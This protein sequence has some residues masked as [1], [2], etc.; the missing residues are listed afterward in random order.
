M[1]PDPVGTRVTGIM[2]KGRTNSEM[3]WIQESGQDVR[4]Q[5]MPASPVIP[6]ISPTDLAF[7]PGVRTTAAPLVPTADAFRALYHHDSGPN[8]PLT[9]FSSASSLEASDTSASVPHT[10]FSSVDSIYYLASPRDQPTSYPTSTQSSQLWSETGAASRSRFRHPSYQNQPSDIASRSAPNLNA[11]L[12]FGP[13]NLAFNSRA[14]FLSPETPIYPL[15]QPAHSS[16]S[17]L[18]QPF[19]RVHSP[20]PSHPAQWGSA[21]GQP[22]RHVNMTNRSEPLEDVWIRQGQNHPV[23]VPGSTTSSQGT[24]PG[25]PLGAHQPTPFPSSPFRPP[26]SIPFWAPRTFLGTSIARDA[27]LAYAHQLYNASTDSGGLTSIPLPSE[28]TNNPPTDAQHRQLF[29][30][31]NA[32][33]SQ[34]PNHLPTLLLLSCAQ[35]SAKE[36]DQSQETCNTILSM[37]PN[38]VE[39]M[40]NMGMVMKAKGAYKEAEA[41]WIK[42]IHLRPTYWDAIDNLV[43]VLCEPQPSLDG[44]MLV[45]RYDKALEI[46]TYVLNILIRPDGLILVLIPQAHIHRLQNLLFTRGNLRGIT[47]SIGAGIDD[48]T[49]A[50][51]LVFRAPG[52]V[53]SGMPLHLGDVVMAVTVIGLLASHDP[54]SPA[55]R[56]ISHALSIDYSRFTMHMLERSVDWLI[57]VQRARSQLLA[58]LLEIGDGALPIVL[59]T[60]EMV[61]R[62]PSALFSA[63]AHKLPGLCTRQSYEDLWRASPGINEEATNKLTSSILLTLAKLFQTMDQGQKGDIVVNNAHIP[64]S[65]SLVIIL[66][67]MALALHPTASTYNNLGIIFYT[68]QDVATTINAHGQRELITGSLLALQYYKKGLTLDPNHPHILTNYGSLLKDQGRSLDAISM[69]KRALQIKPDFEIALANIANVIKDTGKI[70]EAIEY[71]QRA[72]LLSSLLPDVVCGYVNAMAS[73]CDWRGG[74]GA[75]GNEPIVD[76]H[77]HLIQRSSRDDRTPSGWMGRLEETARKQLNE[78]YAVNSGLLRRFGSP[79]Y[80]FSLVETAYGD[81]ITAGERQKWKFL[82]GYYYTEFSR[83][84]KAVNELAVIICLMEALNRVLQRRCYGETLD[85]RASNVGENTNLSSG[86]YLRLRLPRALGS[87]A[88]PALLPF[89]CFPHALDV[90]VTRLVAHRNAL[91]ISY[92]ALTSSWSPKAVHTPPPP[93]AGRLNIGYVSSDFNNHPLAHLMLSVFKLHDRQRFRVFVYATSVSDNSYYRQRIEQDAQIFRD[94]SKQSTEFIVNQ[95]INDQIHILIN[96][97]GYTRAARNDIFAARPSSLQVSLMGYAGTSG[98]SWCDYLV[99]DKQAC[100]KEAFGSYRAA[101]RR[102]RREYE[103]VIHQDGSLREVLE[104]YVDPESLDMS[105]ALTEKYIHLPHS[106]FVTDHRQAFR[107]EHLEPHLDPNQRWLT[108]EK[109]RAKLRQEIFPDLNEST[110]IFA[111][112]SQIYKIC[113]AAFIIWIRLLQRVPNSI[114]WLLRFPAAGEEHLMRTA[115]LWGG[116]EIASRVRFTNIAPKEAHI[117]RCR[118]A[119]L[120]LDTFQCNAHTVATDVLWSGTPLLTLPKEPYKMCSRVA[121]SIALATGFGESM[122]VANEREYEERAVSLACSI[123]YRDEVNSDGTTD[124]RGVGELMELRK[125]LILNRDRM[126]L[127]DTARWTRNLEKGFEEIWRRWEDSCKPP[128]TAKDEDGGVTVSDSQPFFSG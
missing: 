49:T 115:L 19:A 23:Q 75:I 4:I 128:W 104:E 89:H 108:E 14:S 8:T 86:H 85:G 91:K 5:E 90:R 22:G 77:F 29:N 99:C 71:Y 62:I 118:V 36:Y 18:E 100:P 33:R 42:A 112:F 94:V 80:W 48:Y 60:P 20:Y 70:K 17:L 56:E 93:P 116:H 51:E 46:L 1:P 66:Y 88:V 27:M 69:Y 32:I 83:T 53:E 50:L 65:T 120:V 2:Q 126:P 98:A 81:G 57:L 28:S 121:S 82:I 59:L 13:E 35:F 38:Y 9:S 117:R 21:F 76:D 31:L 58:A 113:P 47:G 52:S 3:Q 125:N 39:A 110:V 78:V 24:L 63:F 103:P 122:I 40:S 11:P 26:I 109:L 45:P 127:F 106:Y 6:A 84:E 74:R 43:H 15:H 95:I 124:R 72:L 12:L 68:T 114:L 123:S 7:D 92:S 67:Y 119:D 44:S 54:E 37:D 107:E 10:A 73:I 25:A 97:G 101:V 41:L 55:L 111:C 105:W 79:E 102:L 61:A 30:L 64:R 87:P 34:H 16:P 96:L